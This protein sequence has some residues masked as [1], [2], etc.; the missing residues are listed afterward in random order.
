VRTSSS[1]NFSVHF[2]SI[3][4]VKYRLLLIADDM[5]AVE[6]LHPELQTRYAL[7]SAM[8]RMAAEI[9][10]AREFDLI[11][12]DADDGLASGPEICAD[13]RRRNVTAPV[14]I[15]ALGDQV[16]DRIVAYQAGADDYATKPVDPVELMLRIEVLL[17]RSYRADPGRISS[18]TFGDVRVNFGKAEMVRGGLVVD[19]S[20]RE[21]RLLQY[22][23][24][25]RGRILSRSDLLQYV[26]GYPHAHLTRT[27]D[28]HILR[29]RQKIEKDPKN[30]Q[31]II[32]VPGLG[33]RFDG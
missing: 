1:F 9:A 7:E 19:L 18:Y 2:P 12:I 26:W 23:V 27:V 6:S 15:L 20:E 5:H 3:G 10:S 32:T 24:E 21:S 11:L 22:L 25:N 33:Y 28:V 16:C 17:R 13:L 4:S 31:F 14:L 8:Q 29:L 30:P